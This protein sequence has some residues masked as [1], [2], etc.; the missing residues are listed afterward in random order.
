M[1]R[2]AGYDTPSRSLHFPATETEDAP[3]VWMMG[4]FN[5]EDGEEDRGLPL[6]VRINQLPE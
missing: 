6:Q 3:D 5:F 2:T 1:Q 4:D